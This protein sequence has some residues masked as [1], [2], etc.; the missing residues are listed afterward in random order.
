MYIEHNYLRCL[1]SQWPFIIFTPGLSDIQLVT[2]INQIQ[3]LLVPVLLNDCTNFPLRSYI[4][5]VLL[6]LLKVLP[7][8]PTMHL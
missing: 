1:A 6:L 8:A 5:Y 3:L 7:I 4:S 2:E